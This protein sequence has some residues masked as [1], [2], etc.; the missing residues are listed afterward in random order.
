MVRVAIGEPD[1]LNGADDF[2]IAPHEDG[3][4]SIT[5]EGRT[6]YV[7][8]ARARQASIDLL[9]A[10]TFVEEEAGCTIRLG[11]HYYHLDR[12]ETVKYNDRVFTAA[13]LALRPT[14]LPH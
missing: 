13:I 14:E 8:A 12:R 5:V 2:E 9:A 11:D 3:T 7:D 1:R 10:I 4:V 6:F